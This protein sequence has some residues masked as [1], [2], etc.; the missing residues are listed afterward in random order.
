MQALWLSNVALW[1]TL[2]DDAYW[3]CFSFFL[4]SVLTEEA[5]APYRKWR[6][7]DDQ[8]AYGQRDDSP[9]NSA[10]GK[11]LAA[12]LSVWL[13]RAKAHYQH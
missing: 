13:H 4:L 2:L 12:P 8:I 5:L 10:L 9:A 7:R 1:N 11:R 6:N 3:Y